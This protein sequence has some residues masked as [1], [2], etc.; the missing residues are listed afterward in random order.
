MLGGILFVGCGGAD[1][2]T[3]D[4][5]MIEGANVDQL[6]IVDCLLPGSVRQLG[7][8]LT[9]LSARRVVK[10]SGSECA[11]RG[12]EFVAHD[13]A[14]YQ[15]AL[16]IWMPLANNGDVKAQSYVGEIYEKGLGVQPNYQKAALWYQKAA[17]QGY[18]RAKMSLGSLYERGLG[19][20]RNNVKALSLY[21]DA[22]GLK[23]RQLEFVSVAQRQARVAQR[24]QLTQTQQELQVAQEQVSQ[25]QREVS[26]LQAQTQKLKNLPPQVVTH[27]VIKTQ[28]VVVSD[29]QQAQVIA[30]L[31]YEIQKLRAEAEKTQQEITLT[32]KSSQTASNVDTKALQTQN[33]RLKKQLK[34]QKSAL[35]RKQNEILSKQSK[36]KQSASKTDQKQQIATLNKR[37]A[38]K[39]KQLKQQENKVARLRSVKE[40]TTSN[41]N[42]NNNNNNSNL[43][44][45]NFGRYYAVVIGNNNYSNVRNL[46][47]AV[48][49]AKSVASVLKNQYGFRTIVL[50]NASRGRILAAFDSL[51][52]RLTA[53]DNLVIYY[54]GHGQLNRGRGFWLPA[55]ADKDNKK[56]WISNEQVTNFIDAMKAKHVLVIADSCYSGTL[57]RSSIPRPVLNTSKDR[58]WFDAVAN[59]KVR[60]VM[61]SGGV[62]PISDSGGGKHSIFADAFLKVLRSGNN[63]LEGAGLFQAVRKKMSTKGQTPVYA[64]IRFAGH[65]AGDFIFL[66]NGQEASLPPSPE[67]DDD[68]KTGY[69]LFALR[70]I[71]LSSLE[72]KV[73]Y[74]FIP[75]SLR[76]TL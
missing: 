34:R 63:V 17:S 28:T 57:S 7:K 13:R 69:P 40:S 38:K 59:T 60:I 47:T 35:A 23:D 21:R 73:V 66:K 3:V 24:K 49:D 30:Q 2:R 39:E 31:S 19:V 56:T 10:T 51:R 67:K 18:S 20:P 46:T 42:S 62:K 9:Y 25:L 55:D 26:G 15:T 64:P 41:S 45:I 33:N 5:S 11:I 43:N 36:T 72:R 37:L 8:R 74:T 12:G 16:R 76:G 52:K 54:A 6:Y 58:A 1:V 4:L 61:S 48:N 50:S 22:S 75:S 68:N 70:E 14:N 71:R 65:E 27:T 44:G 32:S 29:P 53:N